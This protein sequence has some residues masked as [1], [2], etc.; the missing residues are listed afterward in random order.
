MFGLYAA[1]KE[2]GL[3]ERRHRWGGPWEGEHRL[4]GILGFM[5]PQ[6]S[7]GRVIRRRAYL[8]VGRLA[9]TVSR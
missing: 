1:R 3:V 9:G 6:S 5:T 4:T 2:E 8:L 7:M